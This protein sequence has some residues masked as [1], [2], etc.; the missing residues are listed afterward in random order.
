MLKIIATISNFGAAANFGGDVEKNSVII[1][2]PTKNIPP[3]LKQYL[4][5]KNF[6]KWA[7]LA[8]SL[9]DENI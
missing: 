9:L 8:F 2:V 4:E 6:R 1:E 5:N 7:T 3:K